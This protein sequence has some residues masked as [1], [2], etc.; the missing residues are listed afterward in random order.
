MRGATQP[1][2]SPLVLGLLLPPESG[3]DDHSTGF[4]WFLAVTNATRDTL[5]DFA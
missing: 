5:S 4:P 2:M 1:T 3:T